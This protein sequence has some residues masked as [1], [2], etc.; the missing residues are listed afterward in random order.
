M[1]GNIETHAFPRSTDSRK[2]EIK[3]YLGRLLA[4]QQFA[5]AGRRGQLL[6]YLV[7]HTLA[8]DAD[9]ISE[10]AIGLDVFQR[11]TSFDPRI[12][13]LVRTEVSRL[14]RR[15]KEYYA[16]EGA[17]DPIV[18]DLPQRSYVVDFEFREMKE[19]AEDLVIL[20]KLLESKD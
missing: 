20:R 7:N 19:I 17:R 12:E 4:T 18:F 14:R 13:S 1:P 15:L 10:Y 9:K 2:Q 3:E 8:G 16:D 6:G 11:P 5:A